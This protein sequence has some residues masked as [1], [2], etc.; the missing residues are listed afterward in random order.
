MSKHQIVPTI[1]QTTNPAQALDLSHKS[2]WK[3]QLQCAMFN[4]VE[5]GDVA[6]V[7]KLLG[8]YPEFLNMRGPNN[9]TPVMFAIRYGH[10]EVVKLLFEQGANMQMRSPFDFALYS[11]LDHYEL[12]WYLLQQGVSP[13]YKNLLMQALNLKKKE[14]IKLL[15]VYGASHW[16]LASFPD[17]DNFDRLL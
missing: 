5:C 2:T 13:H 8:N 10:F 17:P 4:A 11:Q 14:I 12:I 7:E 16:Q 15:L 9:W 6:T 1:G 3:K